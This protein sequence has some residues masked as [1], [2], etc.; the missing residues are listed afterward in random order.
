M[1]LVPAPGNGQGIAPYGV[2]HDGMGAKGRGFF[3]LLQ[4]PDGDQAT[5]YSIGANVG[6]MEME[7]PSIVP[8]M[9]PEQL[10]VV[11]GGNVPPDVARLAVM[12][13]LMRQQS[14]KSPFASPTELRYPAPIAGWGL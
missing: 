6:G 12:N 10:Q 9:T 13:A 8:G 5:E 11:L 4:T 7:I 3:G 14:G 2:R 1:G